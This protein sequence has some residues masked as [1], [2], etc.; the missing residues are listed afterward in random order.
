MG[1]LKWQQALSTGLADALVWIWFLQTAYLSHFTEQVVLMR[2]LS[3]SLPMLS[4]AFTLVVN[5]TLM[6]TRWDAIPMWYR[7]GCG[8]GGSLCTAGLLLLSFL[9]GLSSTLGIIV[10]VLFVIFYCG[11]QILRVETLAKVPN[12]QSLVLTLIIS[13]LA[14][15]GVSALLLMTPLAAYNVIVIGLPLAFL[16]RAM[17][18]LS[19][20]PFGKSSSATKAFFSVPTLLLVLFGISG[21][22]ITSSG[23]SNP[24]ITI[25]GLFSMPD[26]MHLVMVLAN[27]GLGIM[28]ALAVK[29]R[30]G[31]YF[32]F[33]SIIWMAGA[34][35]GAFL[36]RIMPP[37]PSSVLMLLAGLIGLAIIVSFLVDS[38]M[39][40]GKEVKNMPAEEDPASTLVKAS[41][42][43]KDS[44]QPE[45]SV[46]EI[47]LLAQ[48]KNL[49]R[50]EQ[51]VLALLIEGR[52]VPVI[53]ERLFISEGTARTH[54][55]HIYQKLEVHNRQELLDLVK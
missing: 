49:T 36:L 17:R 26:P 50:R 38:D 13:L 6:A 39:W 27:M 11:S 23:G 29:A 55:K 4:V 31:M 41:P 40:L 10:Y 25:T 21:G 47:A 14:Y 30:R 7:T 28:A 54:V 34:Y 19:P 45:D 52:S 53:C 44:S 35:L 46:D 32:A 5:F 22:L 33:M 3:D 48:G 24:A 16:Y 15:Y 12:I 37:I 42:A 1:N 51:E 18:P 43:T 2:T 20:L 9:S 8:I